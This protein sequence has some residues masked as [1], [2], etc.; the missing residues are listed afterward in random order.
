MM[1][2]IRRGG[3]YVL[4]WSIMCNVWNYLESNVLR[5]NSNARLIDS[6]PVRQIV[7]LTL[8]CFLNCHVTKRL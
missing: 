8:L 4:Y 2:I 7:V 5:D 3:S 1:V 6:V